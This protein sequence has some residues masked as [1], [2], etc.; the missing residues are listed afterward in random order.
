[1]LLLAW[2]PAPG[3]SG[4]RG[5]ASATMMSA[6]L[7]LATRMSFGADRCSRLRLRR[8]SRRPTTLIGSGVTTTPHRPAAVRDLLRQL[9]ALRLARVVHPPL[10]E[11]AVAHPVL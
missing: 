9:A 1:M 10:H 11:L 2:P 7:L 5:L 8:N 3:P 6:A 4:T